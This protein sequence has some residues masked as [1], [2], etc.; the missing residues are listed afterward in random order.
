MIITIPLVPLY[1][2]T[3]VIIRGLRHFII[4]FNRR[5]KE[6]NATRHLRISHKKINNNGNTT[7]FI[8]N[9]KPV[10]VC[11]LKLYTHLL[12]YV[13]EFKA[14]AA[15]KGP[16][17]VNTVKPSNKSI[18]ILIEVNNNNNNKCNNKRLINTF[19]ICYI[20]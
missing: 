15:M 16:Q 13:G 12:V 17:I 20:R 18:D 6:T 8:S 19:A 2:Y 3:V 10:K 4:I 9:N 7:V 11:K 5:L 14:T 1:Y